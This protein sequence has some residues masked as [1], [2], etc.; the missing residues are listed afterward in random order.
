MTA[1]FVPLTSVLRVALKR[2]PTLCVFVQ[3]FSLE[4]SES[5]A[6]VAIVPT[7]GAGAGVGAGAAAGGGALAFGWLAFGWVV[8]LFGRDGAGAGGGLTGTS[9]N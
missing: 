7:F 1:P 2:S 6:P 4:V 5:V 8:V 3:T 9:F